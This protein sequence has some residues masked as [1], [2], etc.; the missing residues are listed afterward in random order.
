MSLENGE[1]QANEQPEDDE[2]VPAEEPRRGLLGAIQ[3]RLG[4]S[5]TSALMLGVFVVAGAA[6]FVLVVVGINR[7]MTGDQEGPVQIR[8]PSIRNPLPTV[9]GLRFESGTPAPAAG[10]KPVTATPPPPTPEPAIA[11]P[12][13]IPQATPTP[14]SAPTPTPVPIPEN[15]SQVMALFDKGAIT[16][17]QANAMLRE[18]DAKQT[19]EPTDAPEPAPEDTPMPPDGT[20]LQLADPLDE[21]E[22]YCV[23]VVGTGDGIMLDRPLQAHTCKPGS[24]DQLFQVN[25]PSDGQVYLPVYNRCLEAREQSLYVS[26]CSDTPMQKF[27]FGDDGAIKTVESGGCLTVAAGEGEEA[28]GRSHVRRD[29]L[30]SPCE[31]LEPAVTQ[32]VRPGDSPDNDGG[33]S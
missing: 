23:D 5:G 6:I 20:L 1:S 13:P 4:P 19:P 28:G 7:W 21:P 22:F 9:P 11:T 25:T 8:L 32:W 24:G 16:A 14:T 17:D 3:R 15:A 29:L 31:G 10:F 27:E 2:P 30:V 33:A 12:T 26:D 18:L